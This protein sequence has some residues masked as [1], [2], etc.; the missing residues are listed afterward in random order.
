MTEGDIF[1]C[2]TMSSL[3]H[4]KYKYKAVLDNC[5]DWAKVMQYGIWKLYLNLKAL[6]LL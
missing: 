1:P 5:Y 4:L 3:L 2:R 6:F